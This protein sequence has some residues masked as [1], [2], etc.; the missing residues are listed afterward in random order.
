M[1]DLVDTLEK[2]RGVALS[3]LEQNETIANPEKLHSIL[4]GKNQKS[5][6]G[7]KI[8]IENEIINSKETLDYRLTL[9]LVFLIYARKRSLALMRK[10]F[11]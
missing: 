3:W 1:P 5:T 9:I 2:E 7:E 11:L 8:N 6:S 10:K 4:L